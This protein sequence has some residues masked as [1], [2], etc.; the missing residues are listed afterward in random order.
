MFNAGVRA[1]LIASR[2]AVPLML[3]RK[4][5]L[6]VNITAWDRDIPREYVL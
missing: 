4:H 2:F 5:G 1:A 6:I 3:A